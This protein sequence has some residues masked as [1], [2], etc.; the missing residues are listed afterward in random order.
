[1]KNHPIYG[2][3][4]THVDPTLLERVSPVPFIL[5]SVLFS[6]FVFIAFLVAG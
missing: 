3:F 1:M 4:P 6:A 5:F 2:R